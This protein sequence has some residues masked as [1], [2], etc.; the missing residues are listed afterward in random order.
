MVKMTPPR[1]Y[2]H[3]SVKD[4]EFAS[5]RLNRMM[6]GME[7]DEIHLVDDAALEEAIKENGW[8]EMA[9]KR[10][11]EIKR[12]SDPIIIFNTFRFLSDDGFKALAN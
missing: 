9:P 4:S 2:I 11:G 6:E 7:T 12:D 10:T 5:K 8:R 1:V 3:K